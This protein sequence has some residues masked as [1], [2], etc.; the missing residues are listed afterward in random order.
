MGETRDRIIESIKKHAKGFTFGVIALVATTFGVCV[1]FDEEE[2]LERACAAPGLQALVVESELCTHGSDP[3]D[4]IIA[5]T[6]RRPR[7]FT[8][9]R[10]DKLCPGNG[11]SGARIHVFTGSRDD[12]TQRIRPTLG[13][14]QRYL[15]LSSST[16]VQKLRF[17]CADGK[18]VIE[19][20]D[21]AWETTPSRFTEFVR[22][23]RAMNHVREDRIYLYVSGTIPNYGPCGQGTIGV[24]KNE[25]GTYVERAWPM[26]SMVGCV[27]PSVATL[28]ELGH[29]LGVVAP[30]AAHSSGDGWHCW[31]TQTLMCYPD[32]GSYFE[33]GGKMQSFNCQNRIEPVAGSIPTFDCNHD[34]FWNPT[35][36]TDLPWNSAESK[37]LTKP[38]PR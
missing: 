30:E 23:M 16:H 37:Y 19:V 28:H 15:S 8:P 4:P 3:R 21:I 22:K 31:E 18:P 1:G 38:R 12:V 7:S 6:V 32:G 17:L 27:G 13:Y 25:A 14:A 35:L 20:I 9:V 26:Y 29:N 24:T 34:D 33:A 5:Q 11:T 10:Q 36:I 2:I